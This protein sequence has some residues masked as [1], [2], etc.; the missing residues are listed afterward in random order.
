MT[1][2][3]DAS[4]TE[5]SAS[6][7]D[8]QRLLRY[9]FP[10]AWT[11]LLVG[12]GLVLRSREIEDHGVVNSSTYFLGLLLFLGLSLWVLFRSRWKWR[13]RW[14][15]AVAPWA[16]L[17]LLLLL[18]RPDW[19]GD[20]SIV[21]VRLRWAPRSDQRLPS[22]ELKNSLAEH[23]KSTDQD[24]PRFL[25]NGYWA[26]VK[27]VRLETDWEKYSPRQ[28]WKQPIGAGWS[29]F[30]LVGP[31][32]ITQEQRGPDELVTCYETATGRMIWAH[33]DPV[34]FDPSGGGAL[35]KVGPRATPTVFQDKVLT[36]GATGVLN[37]LDAISG[38]VLWSHD[39]LQENGARN[40]TW[41][42]SGSPLIVENDDGNHLVV[43]SVG[44]PDERSLIAY[45]LQ[46]GEVVWSAGNR[47]SAYAS[48]VVAN[49]AGVRQILVVNEDYLSAH[50]ADDGAL[51]WEHPWPGKS[52]TNATVSQPVPLAG[53]RVFLSKAY[54]AG[55]TLLQIERDD[56]GTFTTEPLWRPA[57]KQVM[58]TKLNNVVVRDGFVYGLDDT[59]LECIELET[60][61]RLW[62]KRRL[63]KF[64][65]GQIVL[66][67]EVI[68]VLSEFGEV[69]L[70]EAAPQQ[71]RELASMRVFDE[72]QITW[73]NPALAGPMLVV[74]N[75]KQAAC[76]ELPL[77]K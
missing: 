3:T 53:D 49:L 12:L 8:P 39:T 33:S 22:L 75:A 11:L 43:V 68:L 18:L 74:R 23:W 40:V 46:S 62:K 56:Q 67:G 61:R 19:S 5:S 20:L 77:A 34:R 4:Q 2:D 24:Y 25:G 6:R 55:A 38:Q 30:A 69:I 76:Y 27:G 31:Y 41:G 17:G 13:W 14:V 7:R 64:G 9:W 51:L 35:G 45:D 52:D 59:M 47:R 71:Y 42:K 10:I 73:N 15:A 65:H 36:Q 57:I 72:S 16:L 60:G 44:G 50:R 32:A 66:V 37:C 1:V 63:P 54:G 28:L 48:P 70:V 26:E 21:D 58:K 29:A